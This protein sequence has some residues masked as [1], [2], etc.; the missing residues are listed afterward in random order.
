MSCV[1]KMNNPTTYYEQIRLGKIPGF[2]YQY[3]EGK[4]YV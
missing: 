3:K 1:K 2:M 4:V